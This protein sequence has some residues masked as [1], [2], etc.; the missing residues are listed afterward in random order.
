[1]TGLT[2]NYPTIPS[3]RQVSEGDEAQSL[4]IKPKK[5]RLANKA[6]STDSDDEDVL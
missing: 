5:S 4:E 6:A 3:F 1:M 2:K